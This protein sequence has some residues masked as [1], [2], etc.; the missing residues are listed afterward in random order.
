MDDQNYI[1]MDLVGEIGH[2]LDPLAM[3]K[4]I[5]KSDGVLL[6]QVGEEEELDAY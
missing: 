6:T 2:Q 3:W 4:C 1:V 5:L